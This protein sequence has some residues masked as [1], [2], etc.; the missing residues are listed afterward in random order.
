LGIRQTR[1][2]LQGDGNRKVDRIDGVEEKTNN[3]VTL[4]FDVTAPLG[5]LERQW[6]R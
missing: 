6:L 2:T 3:P 1:Q 4:Y 5:W